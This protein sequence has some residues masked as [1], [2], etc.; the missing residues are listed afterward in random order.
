MSGRKY[1]VTPHNG[2]SSRESSVL[3]LA[4]RNKTQ[5]RYGSQYGI[6]P[7][8]DNA[9]RRWLKLKIVAQIGTFT[10]KCWRT[11]GGKLNTA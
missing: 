6:H 5:R 3:T 2:D 4:F 1:G 8:P 9:I 10:R 11:L 7:P